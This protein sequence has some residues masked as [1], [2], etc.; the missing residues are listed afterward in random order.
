MQLNSDT[1]KH[2][3][4]AVSNGNRFLQDVDGRSPWVRRAKDIVSEHLADLGGAENTSAAE[5]ALVRR[6]AVLIVQ[7]EMF[8][9]KFALR[10]EGAN[11]HD[12]DLYNRTAGGLRRL[13]ETIGL[14][15]RARDLGRPQ[16]LTEIANEYVDNEPTHISSD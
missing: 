14:K 6:A 3:R 15:R 16:S 1:S 2:S 7:L 5:R 4:N 9:T 11:I 13:L 8:E 12:L 10:E